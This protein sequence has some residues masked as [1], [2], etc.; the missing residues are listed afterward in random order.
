MRN[1]AADAGGAVFAESGD[2]PAATISG[3]YFA[4]NVSGGAGG[5]V[6]GGGLTVAGA[7]FSS[8]TAGGSADVAASGAFD[9]QGGAVFV[10]NDDSTITDAT[11]FR[12]AAGEGRGGVRVRRGTDGRGLDV[13]PQRRLRLG[14]RRHRFGLRGLDALGRADGLQHRA[15]RGLGSAAAGRS[16]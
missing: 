11:F 14:R 16:S 5:A 13:Q 1:V 4:L 8:N 15:G 3:G 7:T 2:A 6:L 12:N 10:V 9:A